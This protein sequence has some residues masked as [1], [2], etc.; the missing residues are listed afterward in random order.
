MDGKEYR[1]PDEMLTDLVNAIAALRA[2]S[3]HHPRMDWLLQ[4]NIDLAAD[5]MQA[6]AD[7]TLA[8]HP[9]EDVVLEVVTR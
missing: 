9:A 8:Q 4:T 2:T 1:I 7:L 5:A 3:A 6:I